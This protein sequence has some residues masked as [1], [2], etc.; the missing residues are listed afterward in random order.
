MTDFINKTFRGL[1][2]SYYIRQLVFGVAIGFALVFLMS[3][4][5]KN[6]TVGLVIFAIISTLLYPYSRFVYES[7]ANFIFGNNVFFVNAIWLLAVKFVTMSI[8]WAGAIGIAPIGL[9]YLYFYHTKNNT[10]L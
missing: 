4:G 9:A 2:A 6:I 8:C 10:N 3:G 1:T 7:I 5:F